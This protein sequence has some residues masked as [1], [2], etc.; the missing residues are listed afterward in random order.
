MHHADR[1][2]ERVVIDHEPR[3]SGAGKHLDQFA[4]GDVLLHGDDVGARHHYA[5]DPAFAQPKNILEH[6]GFGRREAG[7]RLLGGEDEL[8][9]GA[10]RLCPPAEQNAHHARKPALVQVA[11]GLGQDHRQAAAFG[12]VRFGSDWRLGHCYRHIGAY[13][14]GRITDQPWM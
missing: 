14:L 9:L 8:E 5:F 3:M 1:I 6:G 10:R 12:L 4:D 7:F 11:A 13:R 2:V